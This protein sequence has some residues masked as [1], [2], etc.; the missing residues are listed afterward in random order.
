MTTRAA[1]EHTGLTGQGPVRAGLVL[2][3]CCASIFVVVLDASIVNVALP[4]IGRDLKAGAQSMQWV[5]DGYTLTLGSF[6]ISSGVL[7]DRGGRRRFFRYGLALFGSSSLLCGFAPTVH[8]L[9]AARVLQGVG[10]SMLNPVALGIITNA[11]T[12]PAKRA[13]AL[14]VWGA[15]LGVAMALGPG[16]GG[17][18]VDNIGW[19]AIFWVN[20]PVCAVVLWATR[21]L[22]ESFGDR[23]RRLDVLGQ[24]L[25]VVSMF[26][27]VLAITQLPNL[28]FRSLWTGAAFGL[29]LLCAAAAGLC[30]ARSPQPFVDLRAFRSPPYAAAN[31]CGACASLGL[32]ALVFTVS[33]YLQGCVGE[34]ASL[35]GSHLLLMATGTFLSSSL[36]SRAVVRF[37][38]SAPLFVGGV[39]VLLA[40]LVMLAQEPPSP[41]RV[42]AGAGAFGVGIGLVNAPVAGMAVTGMGANTG[43]A[44][45][46]VS[47]CRQL[48]MS[49]GVA[50]AG[51]VSDAPRGHVAP[52]W[53][54]LCACGALIC[55]AAAWLW[56][57]PG[58]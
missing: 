52:S 25:V 10:G 43:A 23:S 14:G 5:V 55:A 46:V 20:V 22:P 24:G 50:L 51:S 13:R 53:I 11:Y 38:P 48:G 17:V 58:A 45:G 26:L 21:F 15:V 6:L 8:V 31:L 49:I 9:L 32:G 36:S 35:A 30:M 33:L 37:G 3:I 56:A 41:G 16:L 39:G 40:G 18:L 7:A 34:S 4:A 12:D 54:T 29:F 57:R 19:Q 47:T 2:V 44:A 1:A 28:G 42:L 27:L